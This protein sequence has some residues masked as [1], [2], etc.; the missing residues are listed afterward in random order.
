MICLLLVRYAAS[1]VMTMT[2]GKTDPTYFTD[3]EVQE[4][5]QHGARLGKVIQIGSHIVDKYPILAYVPFITARL[6]RW[7]REELALFTS[8]VGDVRQKM[9]SLKQDH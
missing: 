1:V 5:A 9:V 3:P 8:L 2:Y 7:Q 4:M 6:R